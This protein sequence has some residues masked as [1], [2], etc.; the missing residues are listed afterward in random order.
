MARILSV[1]SAFPPHL[2]SMEMST[3][4]A[5]RMSCRDDGEAEK[6]AKLYRRTGVDT[7]GSVLLE[8]PDTGAITQSFYPPM[9]AEPQGP[10]T[11]DRNSRFAR[12]A[13]PLAC[14]AAGEAILQSGNTADQITHLVIV[15]CTGFNSPGVDIELIEQLGLAPT[16]Q[17]IQI[18]FMGC[19]A[20]INAMRTARG[21]VA[22]D[23]EACV[24]ICCVELCSLHYQYG[25]DVQRIVSG[26][27]FADGAAAMIVAGS[28]QSS[29][30]DSQSLGVIEATGSYLIP[31]SR[32]AMTWTIG[33]HGFQ[34]TLAATVPGFVE[35]YLPGFL[36]GWLRSHGESI[37]S[38]GGWAVHPGGVRI[39]HAVETALHLD[40]TALETSRR[41]LREHGNM[42]SATLGVILAEFHR[43]GVPRPWLTLGF[44]PGLE[45]EVALLR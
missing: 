27:L 26:A 3:Y 34:M 1:A 16:T 10:T 17:R 43:Q 2:A 19:H 39:L 29:A 40:G 11:L 25:Y 20:L 6:V 7:R 41:V 33:D 4:Y 14:Q 23:P 45:V 22:A 44:G 13:P 36:D 18:G 15:T 37:D 42:S 5:Q 24:L 35:R 38:I 28:Q 32:D 12:E 21:L 8:Q 31:D 30:A 9:T